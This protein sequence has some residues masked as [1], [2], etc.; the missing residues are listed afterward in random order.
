[1]KHKAVP[2]DWS[3]QFFHIY[4]EAVATAPTGA[5]L[6]EVGSWWGKS[7]IYLAELAKYANKALKVYSVDLW[8][9]RPW[10]PEHA[11]LFGHPENHESTIH[12]QHHDSVFETFAYHVEQSGLSPDP[13]RIMRMDSLEAARLFINSWLHFVFLDDEHSYDHVRKELAAWWPLVLPGGMIAGDDYKP[14]FN[15]VIAAVDQFAQDKGL[16]VVTTDSTWKI[17]K[18]Y[19]CGT[20]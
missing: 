2:S 4:E 10:M 15:G 16:K 6:V 3:S 7:A 18:A 9:Y 5:S 17:Q 19:E 13:L 1:V 11:W 20:R 8:D 12:A 14:E